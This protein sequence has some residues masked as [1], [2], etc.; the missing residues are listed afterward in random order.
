MNQSDEQELEHYRRTHQVI[1]WL[2]DLGIWSVKIVVAHAIFWFAMI[3]VKAVYTD[4]QTI[5]FVQTMILAVAMLWA[6]VN[7]AFSGPLWQAFRKS[8]EWAMP[9][10]ITMETTISSIQ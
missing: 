1:E 9:L 8:I 2:G 5:H 3:G 4:Y 10:L 6:L 7:V